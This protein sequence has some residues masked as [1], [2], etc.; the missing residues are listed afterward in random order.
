[1]KRGGGGGPP[2][3]KGRGG[4]PTFDY[5][6][7]PVCRWAAEEAW[8][9][10]WAHPWHHSVR[11]HTLVPPAVYA[12]HRESGQAAGTAPKRITIHQE[13][14]FRLAWATLR[15]KAT[16]TRQH[17][18][19]GGRGHV[20]TVAPHIT[21]RPHCPQRC[22]APSTACTAAWSR[23]WLTHSAPGCL[24]WLTCGGGYGVGGER[25]VGR[26]SDRI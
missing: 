11:F 9:R 24:P 8:G 3:P 10:G 13:A 17:Q 22:L 12:W 19:G 7:E 14:A 2:E 5:S 23:A 6:C 15:E 1:M 4:W 26:E 18:V 20:S 16:K 21:L 25:A